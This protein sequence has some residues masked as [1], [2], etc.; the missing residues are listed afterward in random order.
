MLTLPSS[1]IYVQV[2]VYR[3]KQKQKLNIW[4]YKVYN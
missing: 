1:D 4:N 2:D 3:I